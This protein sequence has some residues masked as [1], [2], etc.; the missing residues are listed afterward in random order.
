[1]AAAFFNRL[2]AYRFGTV[3]PAFDVIESRIADDGE[4]LVRGPSVFKRYWN[5]PE[6]TADAIDAQGWFHTGDIGEFQ[7]G[8]LRITDR[9]KDLI[10]L[11]VGKKVPPQMLENAL[12]L[13]SPLISQVL[14]YGD[15]RSYCVALVTLT[16][17]AVKK[18]GAGEGARA[19]AD[20]EVKAELDKAVA[21]LNATLASH[22]TIKRYVVLGEDFT[23][24]NGL[25]T[26][27]MKV[28]RKLAVE[29]HRTALESLYG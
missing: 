2:E 25:L 16:E 26:P 23:E 17:D 10:V 13:R 24:A 1:M 14:A 28:K 15:K 4:I 20:P 21:A 7:D 12:K 5:N 29:R 9:K 3:G 27:S 18:Y 22:E 8:F 19:A 6:A 11:A